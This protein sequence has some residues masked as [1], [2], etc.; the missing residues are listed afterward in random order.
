MS[1]GTSL[2]DPVEFHGGVFTSY[3]YTDNYLG[4]SRDEESENIY[5][6]GPSL[7]L[8]WDRQT[9]QLELSGHAARSI[10]R[11]FDDDDS[12]D[13]FLDSVFTATTTR[14]SLN[15]SYGF[16]KTNRREALSEVSGDARRQRAALAYTRALTRD[17][18][19]GLDYGYSTEN[20]RYPNDDIVSHSITGTVADRV[21]EHTTVRLNGGYDLHYYYNGDQYDTW[22]VRSG[23]GVDQQVTDRTTISLDG[24]RNHQGRLH[25]PDADITSAYLTWA[26]VL[27]SNM[28]LSLS[29]G[30]NWL[31]M[32]DLDNERTHLARG[33]ITYHTQYDTL[34]LRASRE[35][36]AE[37]TEDRY[38]IYDTRSVEL[39]WRR[40]MLRELFLMTTVSYDQRKPVSDV[41]AYSRI[42]DE[43]DFAGSISLN[44]TLFEHLIITP[45]YRRLH[46][47]VEETDITIP[48]HTV[49]ETEREN[50]YMIRVEV[51]Y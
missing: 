31:S 4:T 37:F 27:T 24:S 32:E 28:D 47:V 25:L 26:Y 19:L 10:H 8:L 34:A 44:W 51:R 7:S 15:I 6:A 33:E 11:K 39:S 43:K 12:T 22:N 35:Y 18:T 46:R 5:E 48:G 49:T 50:R 29:G 2:A 38:G 30:Y 14:D 16:S 9:T 13:V 17:V 21:L 23:L 36:E 1:C 20:Y 3:E 45:S 42:E 41:D 40:D